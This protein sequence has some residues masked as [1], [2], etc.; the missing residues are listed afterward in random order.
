MTSTL[1]WG[2]KTKFTSSGKRNACP[3]CGRTKDGDCRFNDTTLFCHNSP[4]PSQFNWHGQTWFLHRTACGH[5]GACK[6]FKPWPPAD[7]RRSHRPR[8]KRHVSTSWRRLLP[9]FIAEWRE[10]MACPEFEL[11]SPD[12]LRHY[13]K[14]IYKAEYKGEQLLPLLVDAARDN[15]K[16]RR[17]VIALQHKL[18]ALRYQRH[19]VDWFRKN[20]LGCPELNGWLS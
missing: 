5:T 8:P 7:Q 20:A 2:G 17:H 14:A 11:C 13:F 3:G 4:L 19:D 12:Q 15:A 6:L 10:A 9:Q 1:N 18:K 16:N